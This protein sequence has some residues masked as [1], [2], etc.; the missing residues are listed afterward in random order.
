MNVKAQSSFRHKKSSN[1]WLWNVGRVSFFLKNCCS[2]RSKRLEAVRSRRCSCGSWN[3]QVCKQLAQRSHRHMCLFDRTEDRIF[4]WTMILCSSE[5]SDV[6]NMKVHRLTFLTQTTKR[7]CSQFRGRE[8]EKATQL[9]LILH[10]IWFESEHLKLLK[11]RA[12]TSTVNL[13]QFYVV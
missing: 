9:F 3:E 4:I 11:H 10:G 2:H 7:S 13:Y 5:S 12:K 8:T 6:K 1:Y